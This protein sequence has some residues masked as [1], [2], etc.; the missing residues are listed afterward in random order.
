MTLDLKILHS[1][2]RLI[3]GKK[4]EKK[5]ERNLIFFLIILYFTICSFVQRWTYQQTPSNQI[6]V[7]I[8]SVHV[9]ETNDHKMF[10]WP[11]LG[12]M[13]LNTFLFGI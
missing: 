7:G 2:G 3:F 12:P 6:A 10:P 11:S 1:F 9:F 8:V 13:W 5:N 4:K